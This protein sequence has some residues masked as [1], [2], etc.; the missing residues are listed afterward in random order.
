MRGGLATCGAAGL[1]G[2]PGGAGGLRGGGTL[3]RA[4]CAG[5]GF[6]G[7]GGLLTAGGF[8][9]T[10]GLGCGL[11]GIDGLAGEAAGGFG[12][13]CLLAGSGGAT[14]GFTGAAGVPALVAA[15]PLG[16]RIGPAGFWTGGR[17]GPT[18][19]RNGARVPTTGILG[20]AEA[21]KPRRIGLG[22]RRRTTRRLF[23]LGNCSSGKAAV[24]F[25]PSRLPI[26]LRTLSAIEESKALEWDLVSWIPNRGRIAMISL[27]L[28]PS[29]RANSLIRIV[30]LLLRRLSSR[31][32]THS[33]GIGHGAVAG[34]APFRERVVRSR[35]PV[36]IHSTKALQ[37]GQIVV[38]FL[39]VVFLLAASGVGLARQ[40][41]RG[42]GSG[43]F[44]PLLALLLKL[45][46]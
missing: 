33:R 10:G 28:T 6:G 45:R 41:R 21:P 14:L 27:E 44:L 17:I 37:F 29:S 46:M 32:P 3:G 11:T 2:S 20:G 23:G 42:G 34:S 31:A 38:D 18:G 13:G 36:T 7:T 12:P 5:G 4:G 22:L 19:G 15:G 35:A 16:S 43:R 39:V 30:L 9:A 26:L 8:G 1:G 24:F 25:L 40:H